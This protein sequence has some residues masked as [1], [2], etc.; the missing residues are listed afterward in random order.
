MRRA[1]GL[2]I[3]LTLAAPASALELWSEAGLSTRVSDPLSMDLGANWRSRTGPFATEQVFGQVGAT[4]RLHKHWR[5]A[6]G[7]RAGTKDD[8]GS[9][10]FAHRLTLDG[11]GRFKVDEFQFRWRERYQVRLK[12]AGKDTRHTLRSGLRTTLD[13]DLPVRPGVDVETFINLGDGDQTGSGVG[14]DKVRVS[15]LLR[16]PMG[17]VD[18]DLA[19]RAEIGVRDAEGSHILGVGVTGNVDLRA[20]ED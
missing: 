2:G 15:V 1:L 9:T 12:S 14:L 7:Y 19:Y 6:T 18:L 8:G 11:M 13:F 5:V 17:Q 3:A 16:V 20:D 4:V 10:L